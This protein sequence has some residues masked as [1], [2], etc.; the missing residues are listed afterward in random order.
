M[1][2]YLTQSRILTF[3]LTFAF[4]LTSCQPPAESTPVATE[5][6]PTP[7]PTQ[8]APAEV[9]P[10]QTESPTALN[11][12]IMLDPATTQDA[13]SLMVS[14]YIYEGL[15][16]LDA[17]GNPQP[18][19]AESWVVSDDQLDYIFTLRANAA[20]SD[21]TPVTPDVVAENFNRWFD[22]QHPLHGNGNYA[23]WQETFL[24]FHGEKTED[25]RP[26]SM[27][28]GI[29]K[30]DFNT[31]LIH[32]NRLEPNLL[33]YLADPAFAILNTSA[34]AADSAYGGSDSTIISSGPYVV[35]SWTDAGLTLSPNP[36]Y[37]GTKPQEDL[38]FIWR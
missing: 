24:G 35:S 34:L 10:T 21:G 16:S 13:D 11:P 38:K 32:L 33:T 8:A 27:V 2:S 6:Q 12:D 7:L 29:Q 15:V 3:L 37:W 26:K 25:K 20:F 28:D 5:Q 30:V 1:A 19:L 14:Q 9:S 4:V 36:K 18:A 23:A 17:D 22:P 31:V